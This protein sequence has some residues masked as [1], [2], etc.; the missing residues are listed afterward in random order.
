[1]KKRVYIAACT[2]VALMLLS[3]SCKKCKTC[4]CF[5]NGTV[6]EQNN[7]AYGGDFGALA[8]WEKY[9]VEVAGYDSVKCN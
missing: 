9:L 4:Q 7:C 2:I 5:H 8:T 1:M 3:D 6:Q